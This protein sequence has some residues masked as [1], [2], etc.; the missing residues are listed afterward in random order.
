MC[1]RCRAVRWRARDDIV[2]TG[3]PLADQLEPFEAA[4]LV[5]RGGLQRFVAVHHRER[6][7]GVR[8]KEAARVVGLQSRAR[9]LAASAGD[10]RSCLVIHG[11]I[12]PRFADST[13]CDRST[14]SGCRRCETI[15]ASPRT[16]APRDHRAGTA[17]TASRTMP[18]GT[19][20]AAASKVGRKS[21]TSKSLR[22][23]ER[24]FGCD[25]DSRQPRGQARTSRQDRA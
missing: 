17:P 19:L 13:P 6:H 18:I 16:G 22:Q 2:D 5:V 23:H 8:R 9:P 3:K 14:C 20:I 21:S 25:G 4:V 24:L 1:T 7:V 15:A 11:S 12:A 10:A